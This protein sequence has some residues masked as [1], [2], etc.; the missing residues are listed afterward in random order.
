MDT[1]VI[2]RPSVL[3]NRYGYEIARLDKPIATGGFGEIWLAELL[4][5]LSLLARRIVLGEDDPRIL[6]LEMP[7]TEG[8][9]MMDPEAIRR[10]YDTAQQYWN[11]IQKMGLKRSM[12]TYQSFVELVDPA[13]LE[14]PRIAVKVLKPKKQDQSNDEFQK[15]LQETQARFKQESDML[16]KFAHPHNHKN[17]IR[18]YSLVNDPQL[19][20]C[21]LQ[22]YIEGKTLEEHLKAQE[23]YKMQPKAALDIIVQLAD[24]VNRI[25]HEGIIHRDLKPANIIL[26]KEDHTPVI[27]DFG[28]SRREESNLTMDKIIGTPRYMAPEQLLSTADERSDVYSLA[29]ILFE[30]I[31]GCPAYPYAH[32]NEIMDK[33]K[34]PAHPSRIVQYA[35]NIHP[36]LRQLIEAGRA[37]NPEAR[38]TDE[39]FLDAAKEVIQVGKF[40]QDTP[41]GASSTL[42][43]KERSRALR[44]IK[45]T[46]ADVQ[47]LEQELQ[48]CALDERANA[49]KQH[50]DQEDFTKAKDEIEAL[51][52]ELN[53]LPER[54]EELQSH[55]DKY[56]AHLKQG[57]ALK[58]VKTHLAQASEA[59]KSGD[60]VQFGEL[61]DLTERALG[62]LPEKQRVTSG[63]VCKN[64]RKE[65]DDDYKMPVG[66]FKLAKEH[67]DSAQAAY[68]ALELGYAAKKPVSQDAVDSLLKKIEEADVDLKDHKSPDKV[69]PAYDAALAV[70][71]ELRKKATKLSSFAGALTVLHIVKDKYEKLNAV[72]G[73]GNLVDQKPMD[74]LLTQLDALTKDLSVFEPT[75]QGAFYTTATKYAGELREVIADLHTR[76]APKA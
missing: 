29:T 8:K 49:I 21:L 23:G 67:L 45:M 27:I 30:M 75:K 76:V 24:A 57:I 72:Y 66:R 17:I 47:T 33:L 74:D 69:G 42:I 65:Y 10:V 62:D 55:L 18:R 59:R 53:A 1:P 39:E 37:K 2:P 51:Q 46:H 25:H 11:D 38:L 12:E 14:N 64:L 4:N 40:Y 3:R 35:R 19:G 6:N 26:R 20:E 22:E 41:L 16:K 61:L 15:H 54:D 68:T 52:K 36:F 50:L 44:R 48:A 71:G 32:T 28:I 60:Y 73:T 7:Y 5:P 63:E 58:Q 70:A 34:Q 13:L 43:K 31:S 9:R 56:T